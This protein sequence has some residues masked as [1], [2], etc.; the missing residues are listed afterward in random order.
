ML[1]VKC[2]YCLTKIKVWR[3]FLIMVCKIWQRLAGLPWFEVM[4]L[5][6]NH[7]GEIMFVWEILRF[8]FSKGK[9]HLTHTFGSWIYIFDWETSQN[10]Q[11]PDRFSWPASTNKDSGITDHAAND[12][13]PWDR[14]KHVSPDVKSQSNES[15]REGPVVI[16]QIFFRPIRTFYRPHQW[17]KKINSWDLN[18]MFLGKCFSIDLMNINMHNDITN[19]TI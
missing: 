7:P 8:Q 11:L 5:H 2:P 15:L 14:Y 1:F 16:K 10:T 12:W 3:H 18:L 13:S 9:C 4:S 17:L 6:S 19:A